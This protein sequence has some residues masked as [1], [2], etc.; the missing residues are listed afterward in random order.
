MFF[1]RLGRWELFRFSQEV[2]IE[3]TA[4]SVYAENCPGSEQDSFI[5]SGSS[6]SCIFGQRGM[7]VS[8][9]LEAH[10]EEKQG[11][12]GAKTKDGKSCECCPAFSRKPGG[13]VTSLADTLEG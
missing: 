5:T 1:P 6:C 4:Y 7:D 13:S 12:D 3:R 9:I 11:G 8:T 2:N 10:P